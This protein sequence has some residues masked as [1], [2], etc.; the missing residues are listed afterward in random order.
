MMSDF[1]K[2]KEAVRMYY[3]QHLSKAEICRRLECTRPWLDRWLTRYNPDHVEASLT[4]KNPGFQKGSLRS[5]SSEIRQQVIEMRRQRADH[6]QWPYALIGA[7]AIHYELKSLDSP[8]VPPPRT[9]HRWLVDAGFVHPSTRV[10]PS[11]ESKP[12]PF[13]EVSTVN[14]IH[15]LDLKGPIYLRGSNQKYYV[16][17]LR[18]RFSHRCALDVLETRQ[19]QGIVNFLVQSWHWLGLPQY[20]QMDNALEFRGSHRYPRSFGLVVRTATDL[21]VEPVFNPPYEPWRNGGV[22]RHNGFLESRLLTIECADLDALK[23]AT[24]HCQD[25]CNQTHRSEKLNGATP[26]EVAMNIPKQFPPKEYK[27]HQAN[28]LEHNKGYVSFI[29]LIRKS[30][31]IT[32]GTNDRFMVEPALAYTYVQARVNM[33]QRTVVISQNGTTLKHYDY[34]NETIGQWAEDHEKVSC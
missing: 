34:S 5:W 17:V 20:L 26:D 13:S 32:L 14:E 6:S 16:V 25:A 12:I 15:Q 24:Q 22:E 33:A 27:K 1:E 19:A 30:G 2:R 28:T 8:E 10:Q 4:N 11:R 23:Q 18:D 21:D 9:I 7:R 3:Y 29:R 31:R